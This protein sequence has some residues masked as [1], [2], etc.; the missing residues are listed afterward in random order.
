MG[1]IPFRTMV[2]GDISLLPPRKRYM[3][4]II[5]F[6]NVILLRG[7]FSLQVTL[8][9]STLLFREV[10]LMAVSMPLIWLLSPSPLLGLLC[11]LCMIKIF[12]KPG[13]SG[14]L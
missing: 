14:G 13:S 2:T 10:L 3:R 8:I 1:T 11:A 9:D 12:L 7:V 6:L 5:L 4:I